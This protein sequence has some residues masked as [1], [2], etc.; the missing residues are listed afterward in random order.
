LIQIGAV[1]WLRA[2]IPTKNHQGATF[3]TAA[4]PRWVNVS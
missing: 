4:A 2:E 3:G 1:L